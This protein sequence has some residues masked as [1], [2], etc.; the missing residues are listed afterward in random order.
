MKNKIIISMF[1]VA[2]VAGGVF[3]YTNQHQPS[4]PVVQKGNQN[5]DQQKKIAFTIDHTADYK[6]PSLEKHNVAICQL[7]SIDKTTNKDPITQKYTSSVVTYGTL[8]VKKVLK[9]N[10]K[11]WNIKFT[12]AGGVISMDEYYKGM[13]PAEQKKTQWWERYTEEERKKLFINNNR[14]GSIDKL[15]EKKDF[16][17]Y[18]KYDTTDNTYVLK[19][20]PEILREVVKYSPNDNKIVV[21]S[22][23]QQEKE[24]KMR[25][26]GKGTRSTYSAG[27]VETQTFSGIE[28]FDK[29]SFVY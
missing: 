4:D 22:I 21:K 1:A 18:L 26:E 7:W 27:K 10:L 11:V 9:G 5:T 16:I 23:K 2:L 28:D 29:N 12:T 6:H 15:K 20:F 19:G 8:K 13:T 3:Y 25:R 17:C 24:E 14:F